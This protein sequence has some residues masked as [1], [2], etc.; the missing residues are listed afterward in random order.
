MVDGAKVTPTSATIT[1]Y[2]PSSSTALVSGASM[3]AS[4]TLLTYSPTTTTVASWPAE[5]SY[6]ADIIVTYNSKTYDRTLMFDVVK[7]I[8]DLGIGHDQLIA[9]DDSIQGMEHNGDADFSPMIEACRGI[10]RTKI[11]ARVLKDNKMIEN[12]ILD[13]QAIASAFILY[14]HRQIAR[15]KRD[16]D[17]FESYDVEFKEVFGSVLGSLRYDT[18]QDG[19]EPAEV[20]GIIR[21][22]LKM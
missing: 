18:E 20:G 4:G 3:T 11:E 21:A 17:A 22:R 6:R 19:H 1:I 12:T 9:L 7:Y 13:H 5:T 2:R 10:F 15:N 8:L 16:W 14:C